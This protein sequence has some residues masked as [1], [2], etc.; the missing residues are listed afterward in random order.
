[1]DPNL[2]YYVYLI[3]TM[4]FPYTCS[5]RPMDIAFRVD[6]EYSPVFGTHYYL[7]Y[8]EYEPAGP[9]ERYLRR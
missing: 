2:V 6:F 1:M 8:N 7:L 4:D 9:K 3:F 5:F